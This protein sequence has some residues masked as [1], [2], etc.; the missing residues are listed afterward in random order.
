MSA[1]AFVQT[2]S[3]MVACQAPVDFSN[4]I[5]NNLF[6]PPGCS[7][8]YLSMSDSAC[9]RREFSNAFADLLSGEAFGG[10]HLFA[11]RTTGAPDGNESKGHKEKMRVKIWETFLKL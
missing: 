5:L 9:L 10:V 7:N 4:I 8:S 6:Q 1:V 3:V 11:A 2:D